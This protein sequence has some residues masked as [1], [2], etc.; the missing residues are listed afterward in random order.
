M[1]VWCWLVGIGDIF[2]VEISLDKTVDHLKREI[3]K[4]RSMKLK[5]VDATDLNLYRVETDDAIETS[6]TRQQY[7]VYLNELFQKSNQNDPLHARHQLSGI[8][9]NPPQGKSY[10]AF[11]QPPEGESIICGGVVL[12]A[13]IV[14]SQTHYASQPS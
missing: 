7:A 11:V 10:F 5:D 1:S 4:E 9:N 14:N 3:K 2:H 13:D 8:F 6:S 12:M